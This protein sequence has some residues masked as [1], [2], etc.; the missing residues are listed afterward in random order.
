MLNMPLLV[1]ATSTSVPPAFIV[2]VVGFTALMIGSVISYQKA[3]KQLS[4]EIL[5]QYPP[6]ESFGNAYVTEE[7]ELL[8]YWPAQ[9]VPGYKKWNLSDI[10]YIGTS[11]QGEF[12][13]YDRDRKAMPG[14]FFVP[15]KYEKR[16]LQ[17]R[18]DY[19]F[20]IGGKIRGMVPFVMKHGPHIQHL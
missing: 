2:I 17:G 4:K 3:K 19:C 15:S 8:F 10:A 1:I 7:G 14:E 5:E 20:Y 16:R 18:K 13:L 11:F 6:K 12:C 9:W